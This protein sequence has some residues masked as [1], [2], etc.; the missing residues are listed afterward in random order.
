MIFVRRRHTV[1]QSFFGTNH[2]IP[3]VD[4]AQ[5]AL[6]AAEKASTP[7]DLGQFPTDIADIQEQGRQEHVAG[8]SR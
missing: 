1:L 4:L 8:Y 6:A 5:F 3:R 2:H 7:D